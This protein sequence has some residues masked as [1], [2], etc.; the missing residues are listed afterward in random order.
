MW[1]MKVMREVG[2]RGGKKGRN[3]EKMTEMC[4]E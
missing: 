2:Q 1:R 3:K 4:G